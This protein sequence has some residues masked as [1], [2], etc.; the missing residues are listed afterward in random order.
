[1]SYEPEPTP[2]DDVADVPTSRHGAL[3]SVLEDILREIRRFNTADKSGAVSS[4]KITLQ[5][6]TVDIAVHAYTGSDMEEAE[7]EALESYRRV[8]EALN[9][10]G[11]EAFA[12]TVEKLKT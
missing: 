8:L 10:D 2:F 6:G 12:K 7:Q 9:Q 11:A 3:M 4:C 5:R 1:M